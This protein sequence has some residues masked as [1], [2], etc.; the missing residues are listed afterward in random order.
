MRAARW[1]LGGAGTA[2][3]AYGAAL[4]LTRQELLQLAEVAVWLGAGVALHDVVVAGVVLLA[5]SLG[6]RFLPRA[7]RA[8]AVV[9]MVVWGSL[10]V[11]AVP[12]LG[13][14]GARPDN[15]TLLDRPYL[16]TWLAGTLLTAALVAVAGLVLARREDNA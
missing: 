3:L 16:L 1:L 13:R 11:L 5:A 15:P 9:A 10:T 12:V 8:P 14:F 2:V 7:W 6:G 4:A